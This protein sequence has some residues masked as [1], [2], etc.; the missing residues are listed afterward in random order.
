MMVSQDPVCCIVNTAS[1]ILIFHCFQ[2][3]I[4][5]AYHVYDETKAY[6]RLAHF[7]KL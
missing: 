7:S 4:Y 6:F 5:V 1:W 3:I 2:S